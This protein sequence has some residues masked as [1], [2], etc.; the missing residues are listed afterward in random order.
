MASTHG[1]PAGF[2]VGTALQLRMRN[3][4]TRP[5]LRITQASVGHCAGGNH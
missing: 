5:R 4:Y 3:G 1:W 2:C